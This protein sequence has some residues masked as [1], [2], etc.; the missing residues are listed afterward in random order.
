MIKNLRAQV[1]RKR[2]RTQVGATC[3]RWISPCTRT[4]TLYQSL[5][6][7]DNLIYIH[8]FMYL[9][10]LSQSTITVWLRATIFFSKIGKFWIF[11]HIIIKYKMSICSLQRTLVKTVIR[12]RTEWTKLLSRYWIVHCIRLK[13]NVQAKMTKSA[14]RTKT[15]CIEIVDASR[16]NL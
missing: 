3:V 11:W 14:S 15:S 7:Y 8:L 5:K 16:C 1:A 12:M 6:Y 9:R 4:M 13:S 10:F 2:I